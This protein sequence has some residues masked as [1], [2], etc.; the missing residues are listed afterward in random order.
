MSIEIL[1]PTAPAGKRPQRVSFEIEPK[2]FEAVA[3]LR[4]ALGIDPG[5]NQWIYNFLIRRGLNA[6][7]D[8]NRVQERPWAVINDWFEAN[9]EAEELSNKGMDWDDP[10]AAAI[11]EYGYRT[12]QTDD[13]DIYAVSRE[14]AEKRLAAERADADAVLE[15]HRTI[16][17]LLGVA[18]RYRALEEDEPLGEAAQ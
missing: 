8:D 18:W 9:P 16:R 15:A 1:A 2:L 12:D 3:A 17:N 5:H 11:Q 14:Q 4:K 10:L 6:W 7:L 13:D